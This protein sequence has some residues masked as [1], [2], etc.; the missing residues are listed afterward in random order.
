MCT[1]WKCSITH[2]FLWKATTV[3]SSVSRLSK[4][5]GILNITRPYR[6]SRPVKG[7]ALLCFC[8]SYIADFTH[9]LPMRLPC[10]EMTASET[11]TFCPAGYLIACMFDP[12]HL[13]IVDNKNLSYLNTLKCT[14][15]AYSFFKMR[16]CSVLYTVLLRQSC[17]CA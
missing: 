6:P 14:R 2:H 12:N 5:C 8:Y 7:T 13:K 15:I 11:S 16:K 3:P 1:L 10:H 4:Q 9:P 17:P